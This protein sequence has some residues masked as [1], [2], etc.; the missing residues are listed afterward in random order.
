MIGISGSLLVVSGPAGP[1][2]NVYGRP[3][4]QMDEAKASDNMNAVQRPRHA[5]V[6]SIFAAP[7]TKRR[8]ATGKRVKIEFR[9]SEKSRVT[10]TF[11]KGRKR[12]GSLRVNGRAV[13]NAVKF[14]GYLKRKRF[15]VV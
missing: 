5:T 1:C 2:V 9:L 15:R 8:L 11:K 13:G 4:G 12:V 14:R 3:C 7:G 6:Q 10:L